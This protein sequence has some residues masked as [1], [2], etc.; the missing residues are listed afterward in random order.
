MP[1]AGAVI[2]TCALMTLGG[3]QLTMFHLVGL[4]L[5][6][7]VGSNYTLFFERQTLSRSDPH[8]TLT[9]LVLC[10]TATIIGFGLLTLARAP[11]L[12]AIGMTVA[13]G[14]FLSLVFA[15]ILE[16]T[17]QTGGWHADAG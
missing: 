5:V 2:V 6:V 11:V 3:H 8:R 16:S 15:A 17:A 12:S 13:I 10:N 14:A 9:S 4:M 1:L 7:G